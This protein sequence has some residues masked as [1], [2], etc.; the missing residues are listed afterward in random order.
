M[1]PYLAQGSDWIEYKEFINLPFC[2][3]PFTV[4]T[5]DMTWRGDSTHI[6]CVRLKATEEQY[7]IS[8]DK[9]GFVVLQVTVRS[10]QCK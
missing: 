8:D 2:V 6:V 4:D 1:K 10:I 3:Q 9:E 5:H 7:A